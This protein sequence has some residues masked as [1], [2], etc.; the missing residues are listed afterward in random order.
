MQTSFRDHAL[1]KNRLLLKVLLMWAISATAAVMVLSFACAYA[2]QHKEVHW[3][4]MCTGAEFSISDRT[5]SPAY[6][7]EMTE[8]VADLRLTYSP[9]TVASRNATLLRTIPA[10]HQEAFKKQLLSEQ[11]TVQDKNISSVFYAEKV[12]VDVSQ[13]Q[14]KITGLLHRTSHGLQLSPKRKTYQL[15]FVFKNGLLGLQSM[16]EINDAN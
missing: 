12:S 16:K 14:G 8:K 6:L 5:Y 2:F 9:E 10:N 3:L 11:K 4:P 13:T 15:Q 7:K 1:A